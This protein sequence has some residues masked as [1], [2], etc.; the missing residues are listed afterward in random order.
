MKIPHSLSVFCPAK[1]NLSLFVYPPLVSGYHPIYSVFQTISLGDTMD[2]QFHDTHG[3]KIQVLGG[4]EIDFE[5]N[6]VTKI[7]RRFSDRIPCG[8]SIDLIKRIPVGGGLGGSSTNAAEFL[9]II[10][11]HFLHFSFAQL[12]EIALEF[13]SDIPYFLTGGT[14]LVS[15]IGEIVKPLPKSPFTAFIL[16]IPPLSIS[17][18]LIYKTIDEF[19][20]ADMPDTEAEKDVKI[21][22]LGRNTLQ[23][24]VWKLFPLYSEIESKLMEHKL[25]FPRLSGSGAT[26]FFPYIRSA[27]VAQHLEKIQNLF[28]D[29]KTFLVTGQ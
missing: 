6:C 11:E 28:P 16:L 21:G 22:Y 19:N 2:L 18:P 9:K 14:A 25:P 24:A 12:Q 13:G 17:T 8:I 23:K 4:A 27:E 7:Y 5:T 29:F 26:L 15:G 3:L 20:L 10:N 1:L